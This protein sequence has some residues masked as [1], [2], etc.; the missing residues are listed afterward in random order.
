MSLS[1][2]ARLLRTGR[3]PVALSPS[4]PLRPVSQQ[5]HIQTAV[6]AAAGSSASLD[7]RRPLHADAVQ[8]DKLATNNKLMSHKNDWNRAIA[9]AEK[10]VG[11]PTSFL[12][13]RWLLSDEIANVALHLRKLVGSSHPLLK[14]AKYV[15]TRHTE[16]VA[17][18]VATATT[19]TLAIIRL[20]FPFQFIPPK[21]RA[22]IVHSFI[23]SMGTIGQYSKYSINECR[24]KFGRTSQ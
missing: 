1:R 20:Y 10:I 18:E 2:V 16:W 9:A 21:R 8:L 6:V 11:Y 14:T 7:Q 19:H 22:F 13:L 17:H 12:S 3:Y 15:V 24:P 23:Y 4:S 5:H